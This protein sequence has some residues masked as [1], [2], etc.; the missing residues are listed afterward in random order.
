MLRTTGIELV[1]EMGWLGSLASLREG[2]VRRAGGWKQTPWTHPNVLGG[3]RVRNSQ[4]G[5]RREFQGGSRRQC[6]GPRRDP[7]TSGL[8]VAPHLATKE[9]GLPER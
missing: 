7:V 9:T 2:R 1:R 6:G 4:A 3:K 5:R 8:K